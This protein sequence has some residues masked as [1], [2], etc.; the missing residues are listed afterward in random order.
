M[1]KTDSIPPARD[2]EGDEGESSVVSVEELVG[3]S[4]DLKAELVVFAH[5]RRY[6]HRL[7]AAVVEVCDDDGSGDEGAIITAID[8][9]ILQRVM[10][11]GRTLPEIFVEQ[12]KP[13]LPAA[14]RDMVLAW[15][16]VVESTFEIT[17]VRAGEGAVTMH[18]L[19][20]DLVYEV[21]S[22]S[23]RAAIAPLRRGMFVTCRLVP[24]R[25]AADVWLFSGALSSYRKSEG[26]QLARVMVPMLT[27]HPSLMRRN[28][29]LLRQAWERQAQDRADFI[30]VFGGDMVILPPSQALQRLTELRRR[31]RDKILASLDPKTAAQAVHGVPE[32]EQLSGLTDDMLDAES[33]GVIYDEVDGLN[34]FAELGRLDSLYADPRLARDRRYLAHLRNYLSDDTVSPLPFHRLAELHPEGVDAVLRALLGKPE[35]RWERDGEKLLRRRKKSFY[36]REPMPGV[37]IVS[38][39]LAALAR[40]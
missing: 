12:R 39:R 3:R 33:I 16:D 14:E 27:R 8:R 10:A 21:Y 9:F 25:P 35:F 20:D 30:E 7:E 6:A 22:N 15:R 19:L 28:P 36:G 13:A 4:A 32:P 24:I 38:D 31:Q 34:F 2:A 37:T 40:G 23:G 17:E 1:P 26:P 29:N 11:D 5:G 18:N